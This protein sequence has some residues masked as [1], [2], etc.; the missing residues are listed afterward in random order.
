MRSVGNYAPLF[1]SFLETINRKI[2]QLNKKQYYE[3]E[4]RIVY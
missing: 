2:N 3:K 4:N 1:Y